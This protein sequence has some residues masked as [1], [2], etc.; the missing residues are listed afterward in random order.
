MKQTV[1]VGEIS[2]TVEIIASKSHLHRLLICAALGALPV[3]IA[4]GVSSED[5]DATVRCLTA[6]G[7]QIE[8]KA[9]AFSVIPITAP[10]QDATLDCGE[11]GS[12]LRFLL[13]VVGALGV[14]AT[15]VL[16]GRLPERPLSPLWELLTQKGM[17]L[18]RPT[19]ETILCEGSLESGE[20]RIAGN[21][22]SQFISGLLFALPLVDGE[23]L[24]KIEGNPESKKYIDLTLEV[25]QRF[26]K[27]IAFCAQTAKITGGKKFCPQSG[28]IKAEGDWSNA[29]FWAVA[30]AFS[31]KGVTV[32]GI[33]H[34]S[35][36][37]DKKILS[38]LQD[39]GAKVLV[40]EDSFTVQ[41]GDLVGIDIDAADIP[42]LVP[43]LALCAALSKGRT[44]IYNAARLR[45]KE[46]D[47]LQTVSL[48]LRALG[49]KIEQTEDGL[50]IDGDPAGLSGGV[51]L[52]AH[53]DHRIA[54]AAAI[55]AAKCKA[56]I[57]ITGAE[58]VA[59]SYPTFWAEL[60]RVKKGQ[61]HGK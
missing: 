36:Q 24:L 41:T 32:R 58:A 42:D 31:E 3:K 4:C 17:R 21:V 14:R 30:G 40:T 54:M 12:T 15:F 52:S 2:G 16:S 55:A 22:S 43:A 44:R 35:V 57:T 23:S 26:G 49:A 53:G 5:I 29:A 8:Y 61:H 47:R 27:P 25:L 56:S 1:S 19:P 13:P 7:A 9:G 34:A 60:D 50:L 38:L 28:F 45:I 37:G 18:C 48:T 20:Y 6:L 10:R 51:T 33:S 39:F 59:K 11:S 46:S